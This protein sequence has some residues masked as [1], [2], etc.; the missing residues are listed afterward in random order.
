MPAVRH[1]SG[2]FVVTEPIQFPERDWGDEETE[3]VPVPY[4][5]VSSHDGQG[6]P[7]AVPARNAAWRSV[8]RAATAAGW[9]VTTT[10]AL[11]WSADRYYLNGHLAKAAH[12]VHSVA[13][14]LSRGAERAVAVWRGETVMPELPLSGWSFQFGM[15]RGDLRKLGATAF[16]GAIVAGP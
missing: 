2:G 15:I 12:H 7:V 4:V 3:P 1:R 6:D 10:Y 5:L 11:A 13:V 14:R 16:K 9:A 8:A